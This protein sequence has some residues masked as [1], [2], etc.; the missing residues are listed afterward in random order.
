MKQPGHIFCPGVVFIVGTGIIILACA[1]GKWYNMRHKNQY[2]PLDSA[3]GE[4]CI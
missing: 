3:V 1:A 2:I 4:A